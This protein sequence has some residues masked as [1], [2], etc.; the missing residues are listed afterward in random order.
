MRA[1]NQPRS[2]ISLDQGEYANTGFTQW[3][4]SG[5]AAVWAEE[6][7]RDSIFKAF[8]RKETF[9]TTGTRIAVRF[10]GGFNLSSIDLNSEMLVSQAYQN[11]VTMGSDLMG[12]GD[13]APEFIVWAQ[14]DKNGAPLQRVQIIKGWSDAS[15]RGHEKVFDVVCSDGLQVDP[16]TNRCPDNGAKVNINDCSIT[17]N[18]G[19]AELKA[20][21]IDPEFDNETKSFYY[22]RVL[23]NP[24]CRW[25]TWDAI[26]RGFKPREDL[27]DTI[28][29]RAWSSPI[30]YIPPA[31]DVD[32]VPLGG[33]VRMINLST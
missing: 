2:T 21:W 8:K 16:I 17:R 9:A 26:N 31:S 28:Q 5:L 1:F 19:S 10:F 32:V 24:T 15:G 23:E 27:H 3:G 13:R 12:D 7:T 30:W 6:N 25:S 33:T 4:A 11:G 14:R 22:A 20:S 18:V 29:E